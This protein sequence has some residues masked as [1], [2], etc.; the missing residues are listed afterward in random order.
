MMNGINDTGDKEQR[1]P[2]AWSPN[3]DTQGHTDMLL[4]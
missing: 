4:I 2:E 3:K 1:I